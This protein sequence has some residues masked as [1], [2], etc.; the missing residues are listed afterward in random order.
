MK[1]DS[2]MISSEDAIPLPILLANDIEE[3]EA[4]KPTIILVPGAFT[5]ETSW[6]A[7]AKALVER[8]FGAII[9]DN[10]LHGIEPDSQSLIDLLQIVEG[11]TVLVAHSYG[12]V[13]ISNAACASRDV[14]ALVFVAAFAPEKGESLDELLGDYPDAAPGEVSVAGAAGDPAW[15]I[16]PSWFVYG[17]ADECLPPTVQDGFARRAGAVAIVVVPGGPHDL[18]TTH[19]AEIIGTVEMAVAATL[20]SVPNTTAD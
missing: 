13:L 7:L 6:S 11:R 20:A 3:S 16:L 1:R 9:A 12:G 17:D 4:A 10:P 18:A 2:V 14:D 19:P 5:C 15:K 8:G